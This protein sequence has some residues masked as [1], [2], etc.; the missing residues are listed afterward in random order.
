MYPSSISGTQVQDS[1]VLWP[2]L[3]HRGSSPT[4]TGIKVTRSYT[5]CLK[6]YTRGVHKKWSFKCQPSTPIQA[7]ASMRST[8]FMEIDDKGGE[9]VQRY[10]SLRERLRR[11]SRSWTQTWTKREQHWRMWGDQGATLQNMRGSKF[12]DKRS[13]QVGGKLMN[14]F[15]CIWYVHIHVIACIA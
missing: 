8:P 6:S 14:L 12:L 10:E 1:Q 9:I 3:G 15:D 13:T 5:W 2:M 11:R 7:F 4:T